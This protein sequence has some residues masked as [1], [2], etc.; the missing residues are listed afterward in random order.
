[1]CVYLLY[2]KKIFSSASFPVSFIVGEFSCFYETAT[3]KLKNWF[4]LDEHEHLDTINLHSF[5][6]KI[7]GW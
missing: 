2:L 4:D 5:F 7:R 1:M 6:Y 3:G